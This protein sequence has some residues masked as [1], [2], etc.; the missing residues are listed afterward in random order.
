[1]ILRLEDVHAYYGVSHVL[2]GVS[3]HVAEGEIVCLLGRNGV[4]KTTTLRTIMGLVSTRRG[5]IELAGSSLMNRPTH[6][7][8]RA[9][10]GYVPEERRM[11]RDLTVVENLRIAG[12]PRAGG[13]H[14]ERVLG[15][16]PRLAERAG[17]LAGTLSGGE[18]QMLAIARALMGNPKVL[19]LD[20]PS[21]GLAPRIVQLVA[22]TIRDLHDQGLT[23]VLVEQNVRLALE[24]GQRHYVLAKGQVVHEA[25]SAELQGNHELMQR[26]LGV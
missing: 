15:L 17:Q 26:L 2:Q 7:I 18:Q 8:A 19:L 9:G 23:I 13:W 25:T 14:E 24:L 20:E 11:L 1:V 12:R 4:G 21:Q 6:A 16:F 5:L 10:V 3:L 22:Q